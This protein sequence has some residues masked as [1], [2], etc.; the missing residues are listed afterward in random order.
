MTSGSTLAGCLP[1]NDRRF[2]VPSRAFFAGQSYDTRGTEH[3]CNGG[4]RA[5]RAGP[6]P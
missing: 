2:Y 5:A 1:P 6:P 4:L 3:D